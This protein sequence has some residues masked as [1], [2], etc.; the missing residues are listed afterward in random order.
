MLSLTNEE[1]SKLTGYMKANFGI[2]L[3][4]KRSLIEGR[5]TNYVLEKGFSDF[6]GYFDVA[7]SDPTGHEISQ[8]VNFLTT[9]YSFFLREWDHFEFLRRTVLPELARTVHDRDLRIWSAGCSTGEEPYTISMVLNDFFGMERT[10][11]DLSVLATDISQRALEAARAGVYPAEALEKVPEDWR[12]KFFTH[13]ADGR[14]EV[15]PLLRDNVVFRTFNLMQP[16]FPFR[17]PF[18]VIF[19]RNVMIYFDKETKGN[20][21]RRFYQSLEPGGYLIVG[22][23]ETVA[24][25]E[26]PFRYV[27]PSVFRKEG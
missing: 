23:S 22:Q 13:R 12:R 3:E 26:A 20:L 8:L 17:H 10:N 9:N 16:Q 24:R 25:E 27:M 11:W 18:H 1:F 19:C 2:N 14:W 5:L 4:K 21:I 15:K 7:F 6:S